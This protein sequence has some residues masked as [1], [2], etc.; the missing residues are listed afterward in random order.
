MTEDNIPILW[1]TIN[2]HA[3]DHLKTE[4]QKLKMVNQCQSSP[5]RVQLIAVGSTMNNITLL[6][7]FQ[8]NLWGEE[9][10][11]VYSNS[12][13]SSQKDPACEKIYGKLDM[14][15]SLVGRS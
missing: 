12:S 1:E 4:A 15:H 9:I 14:I 6:E 8:S 2:V 5:F 3:E 10:K 11:T 13:K 7:T